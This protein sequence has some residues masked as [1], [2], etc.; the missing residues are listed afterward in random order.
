MRRVDIVRKVL[1]GGKKTG[2]NQLDTEMADCDSR[3]NT[4]TASNASLYTPF[5]GSRT[6][7]I[8]DANAGCAGGGS[9]VSSVTVS[10]ATI[11]L[12]PT[13]TFTGSVIVPT[14]VE[15]VLQSTVGSRARLGLT[16]YNAN[17]GGIVRDGV[18]GTNL[19]SVVNRIN[20]TRPTTNTPLGETLWTVTGYFAQDGSMLSGPGPMYNSGDFG[21]GNGAGQDPWNYGTSTSPRRPVC[22]KSFVLYITDGE[23]CSD[24]NLPASL[25]NYANTRSAFNCSGGSCPSV[26][27]P[28][29]GSFPASTFPSCGAGGYTAGIEDVA[30]YMHTTDLRSPTLGSSDI[31]GT[32]NLSLFTIFAFGKGSTLLRY[33][34]INGGF[35]DNGSHVPTPQ[36]TWDKNND[37]EPDNYYEAFDGAELENAARDALSGIL[38]RASSGTAASVLAS[39]EGSGANLI[40]AVFYPRRPF[41][42]DIVFWTGSLQNMWYF[43]DP[44]FSNANIREETTVDSKLNLTNDYI[45]Q[46]Y[47]D[48]V[49]EVTKVRRWVDSNGDGAADNTAAL[50]PDLSFENLSSLWEA[51]KRLWLRDLGTAPRTIYTTLNGSSFTT[52]STANASTIGPYMFPDAGDSVTTIIKY[53]HGI[54]NTSD[55]NL[56]SRTVQQGASTGVWKLGDIVDSTPRIVS[57]IPLNK[58]DEIYSDTTYKSFIDNTNYK[59]RGMVFT[60]GNDGMLHAFRLGKLE[61]AWTGKTAAEKARLSAIGSTTMGDEAWGFIPKNALPYLNRIRCCTSRRSGSTYACVCS[62]P[63]VAR[64]RTGR[65]SICISAPPMFRRA[66]PSWPVMRSRPARRTWRSWFPTGRSARCTA[67]G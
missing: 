2:T 56:R 20:T 27:K 54:D 55:L 31:S 6:F 58:Y 41:G 51:G 44:F 50:T 3:G 37:G 53:V 62:P 67:T 11:A 39:G 63:N 47:F 4:K 57:G 26:A 18:S 9:G 1:T 61:L 59:N 30:L 22:A 25:S 32:Q 65:P 21:I 35:E 12:Y 19:N 66:S 48:N 38:K 24:G 64:S 15:G 8:N 7:T 34:A 28:N 10:G 33:A 42:D 29:G 46:F 40:Q 5:T 49:A 43:V 52:F 36:S 17:S 60:G 45:A 16:F 14:P 23:P 13:N